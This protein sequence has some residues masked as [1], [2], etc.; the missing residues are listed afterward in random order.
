MTRSVDPAADAVDSASEFEPSETPTPPPPKGM[1]R[2]LVV[3]TF[4]YGLGQALP[5][6]VR[7][8]VALVIAQILTEADYGI[9]GLAGRLSTVLMIFMRLG[10]PGA[11]TRFYYDHREGPEL[12][13]YVTTIAIFMFGSSLVVG[14]IT[15]AVGPWLFPYAMPSLPFYPYGVLALAA[16]FVSCNQNLQDRLVQAREQSAYSAMLNIGRATI[17]ISLLLLFVVWLRQGPAGYLWAELIAGIVIFLQAARYLMPNLRGR[18]RPEMLRTSLKY[19]MGILPMHFMGAVAPLINGG[20]SGPSGGSSIP[21]ESLEFARKFFMPLTILA[22]AFQTAFTPIYFSLRK[23][24]T[25]KNADTLARTARFVWAGAILV[26]IAAVY[27][28]PPLLLLTTP[29]RLHASAPLVPIL[30]VGF[31]SQMIYL[32]FAPEIYFSKRTYLVPIVSASSLIV[33]VG[34]TLLTVEWL[35]AAGVAWAGSLGMTATAI[36]AVTFSR[37]LVSLPHRGI[38]IFRLAACGIVVAAV[39]WPFAQGPIPQAIAVAVAAT[40]AFPLLLWIS[41]DPTIREAVTYFRQR[42]EW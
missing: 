40:A 8:L 13:D 41:G 30:V 29:D 24:H 23:E 25:Q 17:A 42:L 4:N 1:T 21:W 10:V 22:S 31:L 27:F 33:T 11:V 5:Q 14:L 32:I 3:G 18:F 6:V 15:L 2:R 34:F 9:L 39:A 38:D 36:T 26:A 19:A 28:L 37:R 7:F 35:G 16:A 20:N 12:S